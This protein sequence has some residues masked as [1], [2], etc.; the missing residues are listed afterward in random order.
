MGGDVLVLE[1]DSATVELDALQRAVYALAREM[2][3]DIRKSGT[4][5]R[6]EI[7]PEPGADAARLPARLRREVNDQTLR[8]QIAA[9]TESVRNV[10]FAVAFSRTGLIG[11]AEPS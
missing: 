6:C 10:I 4:S 1:F 8:L 5:W 7:H 9:E 2:T 11:E 3:V